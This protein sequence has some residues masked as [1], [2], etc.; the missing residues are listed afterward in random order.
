[1][2]GGIRFICTIVSLLIVS[3]GLALAQPEGSSAKEK[4]K[5]R[6]SDFEIVR[7]PKGKKAVCTPIFFCRTSAPKA[8]AAAENNAQ[9]K[10]PFTKKKQIDWCTKYASEILKRKVGPSQLLLVQIEPSVDLSRLK[11]I[12]TELKKMAKCK[13]SWP[14]N[15]PVNLSTLFNR[16]SKKQVALMSN[17][18]RDSE[19][20]TAGILGE[21]ATD[22]TSGRGI[23]L[24]Q[25]DPA[26][27][28]EQAALLGPDYS[29]SSYVTN[30][31]SIPSE[32][33]CSDGLEWWEIVPPG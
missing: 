26:I 21:P 7:V 1:M 6:K 29:D 23:V 33:E 5:P 15:Q 2:R 28:P 31:N 18:K 22:D 13:G 3:P 11:K 20:E 25:P 32:D 12:S 9:K 4:G 30:V 10:E 14:P 16:D 17:G 27:P 8:K 19:D 24:L